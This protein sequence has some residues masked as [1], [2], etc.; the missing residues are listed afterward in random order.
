LKAKDNYTANLNT[1]DNEKALDSALSGKFEE[2]EE[3]FGSK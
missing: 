1:M 3:N 2:F